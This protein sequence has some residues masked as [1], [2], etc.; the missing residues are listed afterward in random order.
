MIA[1]R[2]Q[3]GDRI[4]YTPESA[5]AAGDVVVLNEIVAVADLDIAAGVQG[6]LSIEGVYDFPKATGSGTDIERGV[7]VY[8]DADA[9]QVAEAAGS[10]SLPVLGKT[11]KAAATTD[12]TVRVKLE[13]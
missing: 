9:D 13:R 3:K 5:V 12:T 10:T 4:D 1:T 8:W 6:A 7:T 2:V 11:V